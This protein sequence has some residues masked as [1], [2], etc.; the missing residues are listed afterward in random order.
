MRAE[1][2]G[3]AS[4]GGRA[5]VKM[6]TWPSG[7]AVVRSLVFQGVSAGPSTRPPPWARARSASA[8]ISP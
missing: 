7:S 4:S 8:S 2:A 1:K 6:T 3:S 5:A